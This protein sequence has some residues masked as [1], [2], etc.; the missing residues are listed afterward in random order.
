MTNGPALKAGCIVP[1]ATCAW[2]GAGQTLFTGASKPADPTISCSSG[3]PN[4]PTWTNLPPATLNIA[5]TYSPVPTGVTCGGKAIGNIVSCGILTVKQTPS[6]NQCTGTSGQNVTLPAKPTQPTITLNDP[7]N[8]CSGSLTNITWTVSKSGSNVSNA[9]WNNIF[10]AAGTYN[11]YSVSGKCGTYPTNLTSTC[12]GSA[13]VSAAVAPVCD[14]NPS[15]CPGISWANIKTGSFTAGA[16]QCHFISNMSS[17]DGHKAHNNNSP[18]NWMINGETR[19]NC[20]NGCNS[21]GIAKA[22]GGYYIYTPT[23]TGTWWTQWSNASAKRTDCTP[24]AAVSSSS[25]AASSS[26]KPSSSSVAPSSSSAAASTC[27]DYH[28]PTWA[29]PPKDVCR[30]I[31]STACTGRKVYAQ[32]GGSSCFV[33]VD[34]VVWNGGSW[35]EKKWDPSEVIGKEVTFSG[36]FNGIDCRD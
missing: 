1:T 11:N 3:S 20:D 27:A 36:T 16:A 6:I 2:A 25:A 21:S 14:F 7:S 23:S 31:I 13:T 32:C 18:V 19:S 35:A 24:A 28:W 30:K 29:Q 8:V 5:T 17:G 10:D 9:T 26:S 22:D 12:S 15:W 4:T 34:G 33:T